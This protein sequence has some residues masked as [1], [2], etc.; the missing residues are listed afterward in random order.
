MTAKNDI[1]IGNFFK[2][3]KNMSEDLQSLLEK[4]NRDGV[5]KAK[6]EAA[7]II[8]E[9]KA[10]ADA[11]VKS[12]AEE[13]ERAKADAKKAAEDYTA[14]AEETIGQAARDTVLKV[15]ASV[16]ALLENALAKDVDR[17]LSDEKTVTGLVADA[18]KGLV[19]PVEVAVSP[20]LASA[21]KA[22]LAAQGSVTVVTDEDIGA[23]F[24]VKTDGGRV[25]HTFTEDAIAAE[26]AK[27]LRPELAKLVK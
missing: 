20:K 19:G 7:R 2:R 6:A 18:I 12:A 14:R 9:A 23:G 1:I 24:S 11:L 4:I 15:K 10:K 26:I 22:Q 25:E 13:A 16:S 3:K 5:E 17:A 21:L 27:R 8:A